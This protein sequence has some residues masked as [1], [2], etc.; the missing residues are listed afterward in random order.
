MF[1]HIRMSFLASVFKLMWWWGHVMSTV[2]SISRLKKG[3]L[4]VTVEDEV[5]RTE[6]DWAP[7][8]NRGMMQSNVIGTTEC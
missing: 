1:N 4:G 7:A 3:H 2:R 5:E 8:L 6:M